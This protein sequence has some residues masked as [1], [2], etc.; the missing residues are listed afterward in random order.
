MPTINVTESFTLEKTLGQKK[1]FVD[2]SLN[3]LPQS[4]YKFHS[5]TLPRGKDIPTEIVKA[6][7]HGVQSALNKG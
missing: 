3:I 7:N 5:V 2:I 1:N 4:D 6:I